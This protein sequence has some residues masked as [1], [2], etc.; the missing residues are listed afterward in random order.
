MYYRVYPLYIYMYM[1]E[2]RYTEFYYCLNF[3][4]LNENKYTE[5]KKKKRKNIIGRDPYVPMRCIG[6]AIHPPF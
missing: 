3:I 4:Y 1:N 6:S 2:W 5:N